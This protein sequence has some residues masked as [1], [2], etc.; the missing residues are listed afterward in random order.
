MRIATD[1]VNTGAN[2][3]DSMREP[4][5]LRRFLL[6][7]AEP[8]PVAVTADDLDG[9]RAVRE[10]LRAVYAA[11]RDADA[12]AIINELLAEHATRPYLSDHDG[13]PW[14]VHVTSPDAPWAQWM[15]A[16]T[17]MGLSVLVAGHGFGALRICA[18][19]TCDRAFVS[20]S[21]ER[22]RRF[23]SPQCATRTRVGAYRARQRSVSRDDAD[24]A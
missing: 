8:E 9:V 14:H 18:A 17:A 6:E 13:T 5:A 7:H 23:C 12:A 4:A 19:D 2:G 21:R 20:T 24:R 16:T 3:A 15:A 11:S 22:V 1:L 10:R